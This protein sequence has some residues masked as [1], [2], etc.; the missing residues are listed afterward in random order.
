MYKNDLPARN[1]SPE[2]TAE[3]AG[4]RREIDAIDERLIEL[5]MD[6]IEVVGKVGELKR[7]TAPGRCPIRPGREAEMLRAITKRFQGNPFQPAAAATIWRTIIGMSTAVEA[8]LI[9]SVFTPER[10]NDL[11]WMAREYFGPATTIVRQPHIKRVI[12]DLID[13][14]A[15]VGIVPMLRSSDTTY[16]WTN[17]TQ[18]GT[19]T[20]KVFARIPFI[21]TDLP[22][23]DAPSGL[24]I[25]RITPEPS[26]DD[27]SLI[28][29]EA[30]HNVSQ[31]RLQTAFTTAKLE[32]NWINIATLNPTSRHHLIELKGFIDAGHDGI[33]R[34]LATLGTSI[35]HISYIGAYAVPITLAKNAA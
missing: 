30:D 34:M 18:Q 11:F 15:A 33:K 26:G 28:V 27:H 16:W 7:N 1:D 17:L 8:P 2:K 6:R 25:A 29:L 3:L 12:G 24:A 20:P 4:F 14:K 21:C 10:D 5:L 31:H 13:D 9:L 19:D 22:G 35:F 23:R 32:A